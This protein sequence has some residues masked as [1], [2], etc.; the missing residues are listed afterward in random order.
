MHPAI[1]QLWAKTDRRDTQAHPTHSVLWHC[2]DV[3]HAAL[4]LWQHVLTSSVRTRIATSLNLPLD[5]AGNLLA[6]LVACHDLGKACPGFQRK[7][8]PA[9]Q[10][11]EQHGL[12][13]PAIYTNNDPCYHANVTAKTLAP[14][15]DQLNIASGETA[16]QIATALGGHHGIWPT[17]KA[18]AGALQRG[19]PEWDVLRLEV[20]RE[21]ARVFAPPAIEQ[22]GD[23]TAETNFFLAFFSGFVVASDWIGSFD[24][25]FPFAP[26]MPVDDY[27]VL[28]QQQAYRALRELGWLGW[29]PPTQQLGFTDLFPFD[30]N[31][32]QQVIIEVAE[33]ITEPGIVIVCD[34]TGGG[35]TEAAFYLADHWAVTCQ[36]RGIYVAMPT[37]ATSNQ[38]F[39]RIETALQRRYPNELVNLHLLH[40]QAGLSKQYRNLRQRRA[41]ED[42]SGVVAMEW[43]GQGKKGLLATFGVGTVDQTLLSVLRTNF[44][45]LRLF[46]LSHKTII[47]DEVHAYDTYMLTLFERLLGWLGLLGCSVVVLSATLPEETRERLVRAYRGDETMALPAVAYPSVTWAA[48]SNVGARSLPQRQSPPIEIEWIGDDISLLI[49][50]LRVELARNPCIAVICNRVGRAQEVYSALAEVGLVDPEC[51]LL[52]HARFPA[53]WRAS[54]EARILNYFGKE[55]ANRPTQGAILVS[56][57]LIEQSLDLDFDLMVSDFCPFDLLLQRFGRLHRHEREGRGPRR[58]F[59]IKPEVRQGIPH[60]GADSFVYA[61]YIL[62]R[63]WLVIQ[64]RERIEVPAD[65][66]ALIEAVYG[67]MPESLEI[68]DEMR[69]AL[70][71]AKTQLETGN[72]KE[73]IEAFRRIIPGHTSED[74]LDLQQNGMEAPDDSAPDTARALQALTR[75]IPP[76]VN[77]VCLCMSSEG[78]HLLAPD[79]RI[80]V[81]PEGDP[82][83]HWLA[84]KIAECA[85][86]VSHPVVYRHFALGPAPKGW[87]KHPILRHYRLAVF[88]DDTCKMGEEKYSLRL[89]ME[90]GLEIVRPTMPQAEQ[91]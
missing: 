74:L 22:L 83:P 52:F 42:S 49:E 35:K 45:F 53:K 38:M 76:S 17:G 20:V 82:P 56:T 24:E 8:E 5:Q 4:S 57:Q 47:F 1:P 68:S 50:R 54:I 67:P 80:T 23:S 46:A 6:F 11:L 73:Y 63:S 3:G 91:S 71:K 29:A 39:G 60:F 70:D 87:Q 40:G 14:F 13:F 84:N 81:D 41:D 25:Y 51:L 34:G 75:W 15:L 78:L 77:L 26:A 44:F 31:P 9:I 55:T 69:A 16:F 18:G 43:F 61:P 12:T 86:S 72:D 65:T 27:V 90:L 10:P 37:Q 36:Q 59:I 7:Y 88:N 85:I 48:G 64:G 19:G 66:Q 79:E 62:L 28:S 58:A 30:P 21:L 2:L 33:S 32:S 89:T